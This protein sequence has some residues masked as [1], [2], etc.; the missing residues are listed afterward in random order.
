MNAAVGIKRCGAHCTIVVGENQ[1]LSVG[2]GGEA[3]N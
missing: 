3:S 1:K 2:G